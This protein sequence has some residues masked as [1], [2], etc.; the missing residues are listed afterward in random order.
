MFNFRRRE[1]YKTQRGG[2][3]ETITEISS[4]L[5]KSINIQK[6]KIPC[7]LTTTLST[8]L[9]IFIRLRKEILRKFKKDNFPGIKIL[10]I[11]NPSM[12]KTE[13]KNLS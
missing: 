11:T 1:H 13:D 12:A 9:N 4:Q 3:K 5:V 10:Q 8:Q 7:I 6:N 2:Y